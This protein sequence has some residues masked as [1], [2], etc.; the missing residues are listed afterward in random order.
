LC[1][2][3]DRRTQLM[4]EAL[5]SRI[6]KNFGVTKAMSN[7]QRYV[8]WPKMQEQV[9][10][11]FRGCVLCITSK[12]RN[13]KLGQYM[14]LLMPNRPWAS[15][16]MDFVIGFPMSQRF[17]DYLFVN[18]DHFS[19]MFVLIPTRRLSPDE[20]QLSCSSL[21]FGYILDC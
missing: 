5:T 19:K 11:F 3:R 20:K 2:P 1:I 17:H 12:P 21:I 6:A 18:V 7:L 14:S 4:R 15:I 13:G 9:A 16:S 10:M 8:Y